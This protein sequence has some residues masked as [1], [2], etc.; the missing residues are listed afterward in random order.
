MEFVTIKS[1]TDVVSGE[2]YAVGDRYPHRGFAKKE[3]IAELSTNNNKRSVPL[4]KEKK[5][6]KQEKPVEKPVEKPIEKP[7]EEPQE[8]EKKPKK[9][10][11]K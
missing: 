3:R 10:S 5:V 1:F 4:I 11:K 8:E 2:H 9:V 7:V 6:E